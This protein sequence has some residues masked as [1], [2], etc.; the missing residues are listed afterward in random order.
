VLG[1]RSVR[2]GREFS[3]DLVLAVGDRD[4]RARPWGGRWLD[5]LHLEFF[6]FLVWVVR[7]QGPVLRELLGGRRCLDLERWPIAWGG[8]VLAKVEE[9]RLLAVRWDKGAG[10][11]EYAGV[12]LER[13]HFLA[14]LAFAHILFWRSVW[15]LDDPPPLVPALLRRATRCPRRPL[16]RGRHLSLAVAGL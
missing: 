7:A 15:G 10:R 2:G 16:R 1:R 14:L 4:G 6:L 11:T 5:L 3:G 8:R 13:R 12:E 9:R